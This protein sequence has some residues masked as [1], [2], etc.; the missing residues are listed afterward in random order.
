MSGK[1]IRETLGFLAVLAGLV[2]VGMEIRQNTAVARAQTRQSL[3]ENYLQWNMSMAGDTALNAAF[4]EAFFDEPVGPFGGTEQ[5]AMWVHVRTMENVFLQVH[6]GVVDES[7]FYSYGW[8]DSATFRQQ[9][10]AEWWTNMRHRFHPDFVAVF[11]AENGL[12]S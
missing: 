5:Y 9:K 1:A 7:A 11:E 6:D 2:F 4:R 8:T 3:M 10:F 12:A